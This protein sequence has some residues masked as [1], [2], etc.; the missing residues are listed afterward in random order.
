[1][2]TMVQAPTPDRPEK[3]L[4][5]F[6][7]ANNFSKADIYEALTNIEESNVVFQ[8]KAWEIQYQSRFVYVKGELTQ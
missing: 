6:M 3:K 8:N 2:M 1:M 4:V 7:T 5:N